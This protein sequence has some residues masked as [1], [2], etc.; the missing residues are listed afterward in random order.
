MGF[1]FK[2]K[3][4]TW[5]SN[6]VKDLIRDGVLIEEVIPYKYYLTFGNEVYMNMKKCSYNFQF[7]NP[8]ICKFCI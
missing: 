1:T 7:Y 3:V 6:R 8:T 4:I 5:F 2:C